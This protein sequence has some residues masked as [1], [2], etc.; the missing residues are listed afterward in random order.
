[1]HLLLFIFSTTHMWKVYESQIYLHGRIYYNSV[2]S[3]K[4]EGKCT[5]NLRHVM[6]KMIK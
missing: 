4:Y 2:Q 3:T 6:M 1:M 5:E